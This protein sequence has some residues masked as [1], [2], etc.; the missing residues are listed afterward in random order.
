MI[1]AR[2]RVRLGA[3]MIPH[4]CAEQG[5]GWRTARTT[6]EHAAGY[7]LCSAGDPVMHT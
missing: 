7:I 1:A 3:P 5:P 6:A 4:P 2:G